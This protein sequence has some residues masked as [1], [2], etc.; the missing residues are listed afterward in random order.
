M[1]ELYRKVHIAEYEQEQN[2]GIAGK[3]KGRIAMK[4]KHLTA[5][6]PF[7]LSILEGLFVFFRFF[8]NCFLHG[9][10][11]KIL[12]EIV[13]LP[14]KV[15][16]FLLGGFIGSLQSLLF[17]IQCVVVVAEFFNINILWIDDLFCDNS[18]TNTLGTLSL[19][20]SG[21]MASN[22]CWKII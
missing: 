18:F 2:I 11:V 9:S 3:T 1:K 16:S 19:T 6:R 7:L 21:E 15:G 8:V 12:I 13:Q 20:V 17:G 14:V 5:V 10:T 4:V 22:Y